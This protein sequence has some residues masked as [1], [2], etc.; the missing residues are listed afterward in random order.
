MQIDFSQSAPVPGSIPL[1]EVLVAPDPTPVR[2]V[3]VLG[4]ADVNSQALSGS[5]DEH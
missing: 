2:T 5:P 1:P 4:G 3:V